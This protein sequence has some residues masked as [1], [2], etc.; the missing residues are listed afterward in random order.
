MIVCHTR[1]IC[2]IIRAMENDNS[3]SLACAGMEECPFSRPEM[4]LKLDV[5]YQGL[6]VD[7]TSHLAHS[8]DGSQWP[9]P[10]DPFDVRGSTIPSNPRAIL[11][12]H[13]AYRCGFS[14]HWDSHRFQLRH[15]ACPQ[16]GPIRSGVGTRWAVTVGA[17]QPT[18]E[19]SM[20]Q[21]LQGTRITNSRHDIFA[22]E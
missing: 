7:C 19:S 8:P 17:A 10:T 16:K 4:S 22:L 12:L 20:S 15:Y 9:R 18:S 6:S 14:V 2:Q 13:S 1:Y 11:L 3:H 5:T 21:E